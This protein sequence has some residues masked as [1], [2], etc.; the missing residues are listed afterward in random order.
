M[1]KIEAPGSWHFA[2]MARSFT[3]VML[4]ADD[5]D[6]AFA[7]V[8]ALRPGVTLDRWRSFAMRLLNKRASSEYGMMGIRDEGGYFGSLLVFRV[9][10]T[11]DHRRVLTVLPIAALDFVNAR[12]VMQAML[13]AAEAAARRLGCA[14]IHTRVG[15][16]QVL[17][18]EFLRGVGHQSEAQVLSTRVGPQSETPRANA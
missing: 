4:T 1:S 17:L 18:A 7:L 6:Q 2:R 5:I 14:V 3:A 12:A 15:R 16:E 13:D 10:D 11:L 8:H 9:E